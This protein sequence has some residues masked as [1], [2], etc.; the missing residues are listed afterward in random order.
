MNSTIDQEQAG[1]LRPRSNEELRSFVEQR[2]DALESE[3][4]GVDLDFSFSVLS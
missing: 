3:D 2:H 1:W 4:L